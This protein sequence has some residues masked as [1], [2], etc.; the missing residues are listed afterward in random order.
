MTIREMTLTNSA[1]IIWKMI[2]MD[3]P[4]KVA[5]RL[6]IDRV[7]MKINITEPR[8]L[9]SEQNFTVRASRDWNRLPDNIRMNKKLTIFKKQVRNWVLQMRE[10]QP[11]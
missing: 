1:T 4:Q 7:E 3:R 11:D 8:L 10:R 9:F 2:H 6:D 5:D